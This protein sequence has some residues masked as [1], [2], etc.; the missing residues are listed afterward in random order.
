MKIILISIIVSISFSLSKEY[1]LLYYPTKEYISFEEMIDMFIKADVIYLGEIHSKKE[2]HEFQLEV[3]KAIYEREPYIAIA[4]EMFQAP[5]QEPID[6]YIE[7][8]IDEEKMLELTE[9]KKRWKFNVDLY[10]DIWRFAKKEGIRIIAMNIP[11]ELLKEIREKGLENIDSEYIPEKIYKP[12]DTYKKLLFQVLKSHKVK[13]VK[14]FFDI[15]MAWDNGMALNLHKALWSGEYEK[16]IA[17][18]GFG[19]VYLGHGIPT[20]L[21]GISGPLIQ[22]VVIPG[23]EKYVIIPVKF[24]VEEEEEEELL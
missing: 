18:V 8:E 16:I 13:D 22:Y 20:A 10:N 3:I 1:K 5:F 9:Y 15:Q 21:L 24:P 7:C 17:I 2:I 19:H 23:K 11:S 12:Q 6:K 14:R 4:M